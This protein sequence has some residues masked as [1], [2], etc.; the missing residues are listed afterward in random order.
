MICPYCKEEIPDSTQFC[1]ECGQRVELMIAKSRTVNDNWIAAENESENRESKHTT[2]DEK[3]SEKK[4]QSARIAVISVII[5]LVIAIVPGYIFVL[6]P[7]QQNK[8]SF[9]ASEAE[10]NPVASPSKKPSTDNEGNTVVIAIEETNAVDNVYANEQDATKESAISSESINPDNQNPTSTDTSIIEL[11]VQEEALTLTTFYGDLRDYSRVFFSDATASSVFSERNG[12]RYP[13]TNVINDSISWPWVEGATGDGSGENI[14][15]SFSQSE[16]IDLIGL[17][18]GFSTVFEK[19]IGRE[20]FNLI[21]PTEHLHS[22]N[23]KT[24]IRCSMS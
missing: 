1:P 5:I 20:S 9:A 8:S 3:R 23:L 2:V 22:T 14:I 6:H 18:P 16:T 17:H 21:F 13:P 15:L 12:F 10:D 11:E 4:K 24:I 7:E 19:T